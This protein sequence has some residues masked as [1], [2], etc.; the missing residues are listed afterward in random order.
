MQSIK[1]TGGTLSLKSVLLET[2]GDIPQN[3]QSPSCSVFFA[4]FVA[5]FGDLAFSALTAS[6]CGVSAFLAAFTVAACI[7]VAT[8]WSTRP[9]LRPLLM[10]FLIALSIAFRAF[11]SARSLC[12][13]R[14]RVLFRCQ[15]AEV[16][17]G[18]WRHN[19]S[20]C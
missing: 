12:L 11:F 1:S 7:A 4:T 20:S 9:P 3:R 5:R 8:V 19:R 2:A 18:R 6:F 15:R 14:D 10:A 13:I 17:F 16:H